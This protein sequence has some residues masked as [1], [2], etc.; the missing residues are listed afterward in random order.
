MF[1]SA[2]YEVVQPSSDTLA[3][4]RPVAKPST[5]TL[6]EL[7]NSGIAVRARNAVYTTRF[8]TPVSVGEMHVHIRQVFND[9]ARVDCVERAISKREGVAQICPDI[10]TRS[11]SICVDVDPPLDVVLLPRPK[12]RLVKTGSR[13]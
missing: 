7:S 12:M 5:V 10:T 8:P 1:I 4:V 11:K 9:V 2:Q 13:S 3:S 6:N